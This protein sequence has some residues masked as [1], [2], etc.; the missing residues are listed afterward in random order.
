MARRFLV[1]FSLLLVAGVLFAGGG[2]DKKAATTGGVNT[3]YINFDGTPP[4][5]VPVAKEPVTI[6][7]TIPKGPTNGPA[8]ELWFWQ[9]LEEQCN[10]IPDVEQ[11]D[12]GGWRET[13]LTREF[14]LAA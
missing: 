6:T 9:W 10:I 5:V 7:F 8:E 3:D 13:V 4:F 11:I 14:F 2:A 1:T 12:S